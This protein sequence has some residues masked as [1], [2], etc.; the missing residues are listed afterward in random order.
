MVDEEQVA[1]PP[2]DEVE[3]VGHRRRLSAHRELAVRERK[4][5][6]RAHDRV[7]LDEQNC[8]FVGRGGPLSP[9][10][11]RTS[12][13]HERAREPKRATGARE[14]PATIRALKRGL[15]FLCGL[16]ALVLAAP[17]AAWA[18]GSVEVV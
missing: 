13:R 4:A 9:G 16:A 10:T 3:P 15:L 14:P 2:R 12:R 17:A 18:R 1:A 11:K 8:G 7:V 6:P 5:H